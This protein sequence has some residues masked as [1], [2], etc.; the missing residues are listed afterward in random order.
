[1]IFVTIFVTFLSVLNCT[2]GAQHR[3]SSDPPPLHQDPAL[4]TGGGDGRVP[5]KVSPSGSCLARSHHS[6]LFQDVQAVE[7]QQA[8]QRRCNVSC[9]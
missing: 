9:V 6:W 4:Q 1:M 5:G 2:P 8:Y 3:D 7:Q